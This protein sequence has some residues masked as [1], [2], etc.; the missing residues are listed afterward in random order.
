MQH[1]L[2]KGVIKVEKTIHLK[3]VQILKFKVSILFAIL[4]MLWCSYLQPQ[5]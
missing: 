5:N 3:E 2:A 4:I 1:F